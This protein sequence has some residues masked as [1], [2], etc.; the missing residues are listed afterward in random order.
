MKYRLKRL[1]IFAI[2]VLPSGLLVGCSNNLGRA[3]AERAIKKAITRVPA[4]KEL[5]I[6][7]G[8]VSGYC[9]DGGG[10][11]YNPTDSSDYK[12]LAKLGMV[13]ITPVAHAWQVEFTEAGKRAVQGKA[14]AHTQKPYCDEWQSNLPIAIFDG[15]EVTGIRQE[16]IHAK[17]EVAVKWKLTPLGLAI[18]TLPKEYQ[19]VGVGPEFLNTAG[20]KSEFSQ[21]DVATFDKYDDGWRLQTPE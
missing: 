9:L 6:N 5:L 18:K 11:N 15:I 20:G 8:L 13:T 19:D 10:D 7:T 16:G 4:P 14:Y 3:E 21:K 2:V 1:V 12:A 17:A